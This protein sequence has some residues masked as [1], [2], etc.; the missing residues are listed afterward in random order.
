MPEVEVKPKTEITPE[1][2]A[3]PEGEKPAGEQPA[4]MTEEEKAQKAK[5]AEEAAKIKAIYE[6]QTDNGLCPDSEFKSTKSDISLIDLTTAEFDKSIKRIQ[7]GKTL[8]AMF[9]AAMLELI[10]APME[11]LTE[12]LKA[13][14][15]EMKEQASKAKQKRE[16][17]Y[18][19]ALK[20][21][22][23]TMNGLASRVAYRTQAWLNDTSLL[24][25]NPDGSIRTIG[26]NKAQRYNYQKYKFAQ[27]LP[28]I[29]GGDMFDFGK[30]TKSQKKR[31]ARYVMEYATRNPAFKKYVESMMEVAVTSKELKTF[32]KMGTEMNLKHKTGLMYQRARGRDMAA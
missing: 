23:L 20:S 6:P 30:F 8:D 28:R 15:K 3:K 21:K 27:K 14:N 1:A 18:T 9:E 32:A 5:E 26:L 22:D 10:I 24:P 4:E 25:K 29:K 11:F 16:D 17:H 13:K 19:S 31:Y 2:E 7:A 12:Y